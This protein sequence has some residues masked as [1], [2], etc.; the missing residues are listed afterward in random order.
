LDKAM[1]AVRIPTGLRW[2]ATASLIGLL[3]TMSAWAMS[4]WFPS[5]DFPDRHRHVCMFQGT[6]VFAYSYELADAGKAPGVNMFS[7]FRYFAATWRPRLIRTSRGWSVHIPIW[8]TVCPLVVAPMMC[9]LTVQRARSRWRRHLCIGCGYD[10]RYTVGRCSECG[11][12]L[13]QT[14]VAPGSPLVARL[15]TVA[16]AYLAL[17]CAVFAL[18]G[19]IGLVL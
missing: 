7:G 1:I 8:M 15:C 4:Y 6:V 5:W 16:V 9:I 19:V 18:K 12:Q 3:V 14:G 11:L 13:S 17:F 10:L 2:F